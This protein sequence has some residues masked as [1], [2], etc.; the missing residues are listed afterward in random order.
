MHLG[1]I[2]KK[3]TCPDCEEELVGGKCPMCSP[4]EGDEEKS[5]DDNLDEEESAD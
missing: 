4:G 3:E 1:A 5:G 2:L